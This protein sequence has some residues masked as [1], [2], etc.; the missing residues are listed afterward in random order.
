LN[1][2]A[3]FLELFSLNNIITNDGSDKHIFNALCMNLHSVFLQLNLEIP[4]HFF[5]FMGENERGTNGAC[6]MCA[7]WMCEI[8]IEPQMGTVLLYM[9]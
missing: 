8:L 5:M 1:G 6:W 4:L 7:C 2:K 9:L 3:S